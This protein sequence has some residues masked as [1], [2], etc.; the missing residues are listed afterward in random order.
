METKNFLLVRLLMKLLK[1]MDLPTLSL[2]GNANNFETMEEC[3]QDCSGPDLEKGEAFSG[4]RKIESSTTL[5]P[6]VRTTA[7]SGED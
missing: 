2:L 7:V 4:S 5:E 1:L 3:L 6:A